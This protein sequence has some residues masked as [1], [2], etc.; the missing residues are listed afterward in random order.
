MIPVLAARYLTRRP[1]PA[2]GP[3]YERLAGSYESALRLGLRFPRLA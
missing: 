1:M 2:T 3:L